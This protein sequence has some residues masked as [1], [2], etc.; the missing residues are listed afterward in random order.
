MLARDGNKSRRFFLVHEPSN[1]L[2]REFSDE[3]GRIFIE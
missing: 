1:A 3:T 2:H